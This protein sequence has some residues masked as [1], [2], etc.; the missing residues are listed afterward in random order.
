VIGVAPE[1]GTD[2]TNKIRDLALF[3][4]KAT[5]RDVYPLY[6]DSNIGREGLVDLVRGLDHP[7]LADGFWP[8]SARAAVAVTGDIDCLTLGDFIRRFRED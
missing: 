5:D 1:A 8:H 3:F 6:V 7:L 2:L 4:E